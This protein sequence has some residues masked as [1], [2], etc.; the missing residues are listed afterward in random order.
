MEVIVLQS[1]NFVNAY[2]K[3]VH[4]YIPMVRSWSLEV[5]SSCDVVKLPITQIHMAATEPIIRYRSKGL[6]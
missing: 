6:S 3:I 1:G 5:V 4:S 2:I